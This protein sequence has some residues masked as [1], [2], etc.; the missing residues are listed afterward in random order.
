MLSVEVATII[1]YNYKTVNKS[2]SAVLN[3]I[4][5]EFMKFRINFEEFKDKKLEG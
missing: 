5:K 2:D 4:F 3:K 1:K